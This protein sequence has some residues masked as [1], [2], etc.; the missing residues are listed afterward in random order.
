MGA[1]G[2]NLAWSLFMRRHESGVVEL[3]G[4]NRG[5]ENHHYHNMASLVDLHYA[6]LELCSYGVE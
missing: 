2:A 4:S 6:A 1:H 3:F 5:P